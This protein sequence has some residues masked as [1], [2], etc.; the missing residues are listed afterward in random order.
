MDEVMQRII[1]VVN[2]IPGLVVA[3][4]AMI[5]FKVGIITIF[6]EVF[7]SFIGLGIQ[8]PK[9]SLGSLISDGSGLIK[10]HPYLLW[11]PSM[12][13]CLIM[14]CFNLLGDALRDALDPKMR[15]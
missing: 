10:F 6:A 8:V 4:L 14:V 7:L 1:E 15:R 9:V 13:F 2:G 3:I 5:I 12:V 11:L